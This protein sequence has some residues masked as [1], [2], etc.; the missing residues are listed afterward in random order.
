MSDTIKCIMICAHEPRR[1]TGMLL[2]IIIFSAT[3]GRM[4]IGYVHF[5]G[6]SGLIKRDI[7]IEWSVRVEWAEEHRVV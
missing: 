4:S 1:L 7:S 3:K 5:W 6:C 2:I